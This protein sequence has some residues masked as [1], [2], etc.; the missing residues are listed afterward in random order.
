M[1]KNPFVN[2]FFS[3]ATSLVLG[4]LVILAMGYNPIEAYSQLFQGAFIGK[5]NIGNTLE[6]FTTLL[7]TSLAFTISARV[8]VFN[9]GVEGQLYLGAIASAWV[10]AS[11]FSLPFYIH[12]PLCLLMSM[13]VGAL[14]GAVPGALKAYYRVNEA[15]VSIMMNYIAIF[16]CSYL[17]AYPL[18]A[19]QSIPKTA[20]IASSAMLYRF[21][22]PSRAHVGLFM[23]I[24][25]YVLVC[26][27]T[28]RTTWGY[29]IR[30]VGLNPEYSEYVGIN[31][32]RTIIGGMLISGMIGGLSGG[33][34]VLGIYGHFLDGFSVGMGFDGILASHLAKNDLRTIPFTSFFLAALKAG[35]L[36]M[37]RFTGIPKSLVDALVAIFILLAT[38][39][40]LFNFVRYRRITA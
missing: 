28:N 30:S 2:A 5:L 34:E 27:V 39:E 22:W 4:A 13:V 35:A 1:F 23:A 3:I 38:M 6:R 15:C 19:M 31:P 40:G 25:A 16:L 26:W 8:N 10:G 24:G 18:S 11:F 12:I 37:E 9:I 21:L 7:L 20:D 29:C 32:K 33:L 36:G 14:W 17:V